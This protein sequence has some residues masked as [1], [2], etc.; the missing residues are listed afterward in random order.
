MSPGQIAAVR[1]AYAELGSI[2]G[3]E[4]APTVASHT[5]EGDALRVA[6]KIV[7]QFAGR[8]SLAVSTHGPG[9]VEI[10]VSYTSGAGKVTQDRSRWA[11]IQAVAADLGV[12]ISPNITRPDT[13][14]P[15]L[16]VEIDGIKVRLWASVDS[17]AV[18]AEIARASESALIPTAES[19]TV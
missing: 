7:D 18:V 2:L 17:P 11:G 12:T 8:V 13:A 9:R 19:V 3:E 6:A 16:A 5:S 4:T 1:R 15:D 10:Q 14:W